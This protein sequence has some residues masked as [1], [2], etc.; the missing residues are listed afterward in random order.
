MI[1]PFSDHSPS[2]AFGMTVGRSP[3]PAA[4]Q[5][6][7]KGRTPKRK[8]LIMGAKGSREPDRMD[9]ATGVCSGAV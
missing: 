4:T 7:I 2:T 9:D 5:R 6:A 3:R 8:Q 1:P